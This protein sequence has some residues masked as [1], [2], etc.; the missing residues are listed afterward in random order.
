QT[1]QNLLPTL[2][3]RPAAILQVR[4]SSP[5]FDQTAEHLKA[6]CLVA[7][8]TDMK[9]LPVATIPN[10][11]PTI[12]ET[13]TALDEIIGQYPEFRFALNV[14]GGTKLMSI[15]AYRFAERHRLAALYTDTLNSRSFVDVGTGLWTG[16]PSLAETVDKLT[17]P[18][19]MAAQGKSIREDSISEKLLLFGRRAWEL[20]SH[21]QAAIQ[22]WTGSIR[23][24]LPRD[25]SGRIA[26]QASKLREFLQQPLPS[27]Q[28]E[29]AENY[30]DAAAEAGLINV[31]LT[32]RAYLKADPVKSS[33]ERA[34]NLL[35]GG[36]L[37]LAVAAFAGDGDRFADVHWSVEPMKSEDPADYGE[38]DLV[39]LDRKE[40][41]LA[42]IS[43]KSGL[44]HVSKLEHLSSWRDRART[45]GGSYAAVHLAV[46][47]V[48][49]VSEVASL[50]KLGK[51]MGINVHVG[52]EIRSF[53]SA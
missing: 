25:E 38:T 26:K 1:L 8:L 6:G 36:W 40:L 34:S 28:S 20:R 37:E 33:V 31:D 50:K 12:G 22:A 51:A 45:L 29:A 11:S 14:T 43:C 52:D 2:A 23:A 3:L 41:R 48:S 44:K 16:M 19:V 49:D 15:G 35:D 21:N 17:V 4:S 13:E 9:F 30:L 5:R 27:P 46:F 10:E 18:V 47:Q 24:G 39:L 7:G 32:G 42:I 53:F